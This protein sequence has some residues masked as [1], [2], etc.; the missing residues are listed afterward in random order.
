MLSLFMSVAIA[1]AALALMSTQLLPQQTNSAATTLAPLGVAESHD[2]MFLYVLSIAA[3]KA[4]RPEIEQS[5]VARLIE[6]GGNSPEFRLFMGKAHLNRGEYE[7]AIKQFQLANQAAPQ[8]PFL[9]FNL[10]RA[11]LKKRDLDRARAE[12]LRDARIEPDVAYNYDQL[13]AIE[14]ERGHP[15]QAA[16]YFRH[17]LRLDP[18][19]ANSHYQLARLYKD[20][21]QNANA[22]SQANLAAQL[23]PRNLSVHYCVPAFFWPWGANKRQKKKMPKCTASPPQKRDQQALENS[24]ADPE[25]TES[26]NP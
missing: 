10:G 16:E 14:F 13:G 6:I 8:L 5:A 20:E 15:Q 21:G 19:L 9:H 22:L 26:P 11:Y 7:D 3:W 25:L 24:V 17:A 18:G 1:A 2:L 12:F 23:A 4:E